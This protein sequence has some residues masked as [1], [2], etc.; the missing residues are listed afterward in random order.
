VRLAFGLR[1]W[2]VLLRRRVDG[3]L[4][5]YLQLW[6]GAFVEPELT[7]VGGRN[8]Q[9]DPGVIIQRRAVLITRPHARLSIGAGSRIGPDAVISVA[10][11]VTLGREVLVAARCYISDHNHEFSDFE[12]PVMHQGMTTP[13]PV[14]IG[15]GSWL[16]INVCILAGVTLGSNCVVAAGSVVTRSFPKGSIVGGAPARLLRSVVPAG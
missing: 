16:G 8:I 15:D 9:L 10:Q 6:R 13:Q 3:A 12:R 2:R 5:R 4:F 11:E 7:V 1:Q 14:A